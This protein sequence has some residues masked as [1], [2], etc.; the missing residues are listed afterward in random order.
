METADFVVIGAGIAGSSAAAE[1]AGK[2]KVILLERESQ[3]GYHASG[4]SAATYEPGYG[5]EK[6]RR[7]ILSSGPFLENP[8][9]GFCDGSLLSPRG[10]LCLF[11]YGQDAFFE[12]MLATLSSVTNDFSVLGQS[13]IQSVVPI[14][15]PAYAVKAIHADA[16]KDIDVH[17]LH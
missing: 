5:N 13:E 14:I 2:G 1:L 15:D 9:D 17:A 7:L 16:A 6:V 4:R 3:P 11:R 12:E 8:P 10:T